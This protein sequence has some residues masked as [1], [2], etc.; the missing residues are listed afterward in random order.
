MARLLLL[1]LLLHR[2]TCMGGWEGVICGW[3]DGRTEQ[4]TGRTGDK[5]RP[6]CHVA[7][8][9]MARQGKARQGVSSSS[10][11]SSPSFFF[12]FSFIFLFP[13]SKSNVFVKYGILV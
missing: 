5:I 12:F 4:P 6:P 8:H 7:R 13:G 2:S 10:S 3:M 11:S 9:G 1:Q